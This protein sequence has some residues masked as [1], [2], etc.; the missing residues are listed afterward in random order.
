MK[1]PVVELSKRFRFEAAHQL[2][3]VPETH[4]CGHLH[5]HS[6]TVEVAVRGAVKSEQG[7]LLDYGDLSRIVKPLVAQLDHQNLNDVEGL[8]FTTAE[9]LCVWFWNQMKPQLP[10][11]YRIS[12]AE[13]TT[14]QCDYYGETD[15]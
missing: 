4:K 2:L 9:H 12:I 11:L 5:G 7:W 10:P 15:D 1:K 6:Y 8:P 14:T 13:T 3:N